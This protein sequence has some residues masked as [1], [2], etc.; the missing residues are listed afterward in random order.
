MTITIKHMDTDFDQHVDRI[1]FF[2][3]P[4]RALARKL[5]ANSIDAMLE[6]MSDMPEEYKDYAEVEAKLSNL[7]DVILDNLEMQMDDLKEC[8]AHIIKTE[9][10]IKVESIKFSR[11]GFVDADMIIE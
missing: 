1:L 7:T 8:L 9:I 10:Q 4:Q 2:K 11:E 6:M 3:G 5:T